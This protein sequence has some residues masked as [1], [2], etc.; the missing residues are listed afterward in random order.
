MSLHFP[1]GPADVAGVRARAGVAPWWR[2]AVGGSAVASHALLP[3][4]PARDVL[5]V[6]IGVLAVAA[7]VVGIRRH[8]PPHRAPW[9][10]LT[11]GLAV[12]VA[13]DTVWILRER[14]G[15]DPFPSVADAVSLLGYVLL[16]V[17]IVRLARVR[18]PA[19]DSIA[20]LDA[21]LVGTV[22]LAVLWISAV[23]PAFEAPGPHGLAA[24]VAA[25]YTVGD[26]V[27]LTL[28]AYLAGGS[29]FR[30]R[31]LWLLWAGLAATLA[32]DV[33][34]EASTTLTWVGP[35]G[36]R[37]EWLWLAG[38]ALLGLALADCSIV[39]ASERQPPP[40][41]RV[42]LSRLAWLWVVL[43]ALPGAA[44][45]QWLAGEDPDSV[46]LAVA[47]CVVV[48]LVITRMLLMAR[49]MVAQADRLAALADADAL[50]G[51]ANV[52]AFSIEV[53]RRLED[54]GRPVP[55]LLVVLD[56]FTEITETLGHR[57]GDELLRAAAD[58]MRDAVGPSGY[59]ARISGERFGVLVDTGPQGALDRAGDLLL[60][61]AAP[62][63][64]SDVSVSVD[65]LV[66]VAVGPDDGTDAEDLLQR[67]DVALSAARTRPERVARYTGRMS[68]GGALTPHLM[69][70]LAAALENGE[71]VVHY[72][73][74][75][76]VRTGRVHGVEALVRWQ[77]PVH[78]L[79]PPASF[80]PAAER[81]GLIRPLTLYVLDRA[82][83]QAAQ[84]R[85]EERNLAVSVNLSVRDLLDPAFVHDV[86]RALDRYGVGTASLEL[87]ITE[88]MAMV[89]P[90][91]SLEVLEA[92]AGLGVLLSVDDYGTGYSS[93]A[94]LQRL[95]VQRLKI[96]R[97]FVMGLVGDGPSAAIVRST[98]E[99]ARNLGMTVVAEGVE[100]DATLLT[101][102][103]MSC[104]AAQGFGIGHPVPADEI[105]DLVAAIEER[106]PHVLR[107]GV[108]VGQRPL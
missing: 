101:L 1:A 16:A 56:R 83:A 80:I 4:G 106:I 36:V 50:T 41:E 43:L 37:I 87:E 28:L 58:R 82:L 2:F 84:W 7:A 19:S 63:T 76:T 34:F 90:N 107:Q 71:I 10:I 60:E 31:C 47:G 44:V 67:A 13:G 95:P 103:E 39:A 51:L 55:V 12:W 72:Q 9:A 77:H 5:Y 11:C 17:G 79:L 6:A 81:T 57:V 38:Y 65:A 33:L 78:G 96:D 102:Q 35:Y 54:G 73:P 74:Q 104:D 22:V 91:R 105:P 23:G 24:V 53:A 14:L 30:S 20:V 68:A 25:A 70:E 62:F 85:R 45:V 99:L 94:Y 46:E 15:A 3:V 29:S 48:G 75:I 18:N 49:R 92:L 26:V 64:L 59:V 98:I 27:L 8:G 86:R 100:D 108:P 21:V 42:G 40:S 61:L 97:S 89:D 88:T 52:R 93:L 69:T 66:G 32:A